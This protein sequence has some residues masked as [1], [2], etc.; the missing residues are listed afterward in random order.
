[1]TE[2]LVLLANSPGLLMYVIILVVVVIGIRILFP[3][4]KIKMPVQLLVLGAFAGL[5]LAYANRPALFGMVQMPL[6]DWVQ[7]M[8]GQIIGY[9]LVGGIIGWFAGFWLEQKK[10]S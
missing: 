2:N 7:L 9:T 10:P 1:M 4:L 6:N 8:P 5:I 3:N